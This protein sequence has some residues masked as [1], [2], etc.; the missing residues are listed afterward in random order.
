VVAGAPGGAV[1]GN[2]LTTS[3][4]VIDGRTGKWLQ[5]VLDVGGRI[6][7]AM[8]TTNRIFT[9]VTVPVGVVRARDSTACAAFGF[10]G[11]G[12][13]TVFEHE[14]EVVASSSD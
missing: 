2:A 4:G 6:P 8:S 5:N 9:G 10:N 1:P 14:N 13:I 12:C 11:T 3:L 7:S